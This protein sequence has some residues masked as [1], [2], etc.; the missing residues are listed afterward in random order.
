MS[1][2]PPNVDFGRPSIF[3]DSHPSEQ[4]SYLY[5]YWSSLK[6]SLHIAWT[7]QVPKPLEPGMLRLIFWT[8]DNS[9]GIK[10]YPLHEYAGVQDAFNEA[11]QQPEVRRCM[12]MGFS[13]QNPYIL[14]DGGKNPWVEKFEREARNRKREQKETERKEKLGKVLNIED[15]IEDTEEFEEKKRKRI[16]E[17]NEAVNRNPNLKPNKYLEA[18]EGYLPGHQLPAPRDPTTE[19]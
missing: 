18:V 2:P 3:F 13:G 11:L 16:E 9:Q 14:G 8:H 17:I 6:T 7:G 19:V 4:E 15:L 5:S 1:A 10:D 12:V